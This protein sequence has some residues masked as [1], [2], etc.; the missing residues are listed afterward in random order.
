MDIS[1]IITAKNKFALWFVYLLFPLMS[2]AGGLGIASIMAI[3]GLLFLSGFEKK[4][5][6][7]KIKSASMA[8]WAFF[9]FLLWV[10]L[11]H[12]WSPYKTDSFFDNSLKFLFGVPLYILF[13]VLIYNHAQ[14]NDRP[15]L[16]LALAVFVFCLLAIYDFLS[17]Y[18]WTLFW[19]RP[20]SAADLGAKRGDIVQNLG[21]FVSIVTLILLPISFWLWLRLRH[22]KLLAASLVIIVFLLVIISDM[23]S[24]LIALFLA[25]IF[26][27]IARFNARLALSLAGFTALA[28][29]LFA[30]LLAFFAKNMSADLRAKLPF[31]WE[32][33]IAT[34]GY[35]YDKIMQKPLFGHGFDAVRTFSDTHTIRGFEGRALVSL[36]PHNAGLHLWV[37]TGLIGVI[38]ACFTIIMAVLFVL[39]SAGFSKIQLAVISGLVAVIIAISSLS[40]SV[41]QDWWWATII[42]AFAQICFLRKYEKL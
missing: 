20:G 13:A 8:V 2:Y 30:P 4:L 31:S 26:L 37:E 12:F 7:N 21:H 25:I 34:W 11:S 38:L 19:D 15:I 18:K 29:L 27:L 1:K 14:K 40:Y 9:A 17:G 24:S 5:K 35:I 41:W 6:I 36:H 28:S 3:G 22:G 33:R 39:K 23:N 10:W 42:F 32:E 16:F